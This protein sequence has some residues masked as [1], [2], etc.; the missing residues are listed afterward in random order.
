MKKNLNASKV[1]ILVA[2]EL[3]IKCKICGKEFMSSNEKR[4]SPSIISELQWNIPIAKCPQCS[5]KY[6]W[7]GNNGFDI[8]NPKAIIKI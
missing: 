4:V 6:V 2:I 8:I 3:N 7:N 1:K 5:S